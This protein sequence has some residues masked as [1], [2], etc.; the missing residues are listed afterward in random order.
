MRTTA[1][2][3]CPLVL[4][5]AVS[6][7][8]RATETADVKLAGVG[9]NPDEIGPSPERFGGFVEYM[10]VNLAGGALPL[11]TLGL[12]SYDE[13]GPN[14]VG[15]E[16]P[17]AMVNGTAFIMETNAADPDALFGSFTT[18]P[19]VVGAC[20]TVFE[21]NSYLSSL[22]DVGTAIRFANADETVAFDLGRR[23]LVYPPKPQDV[24]S[25]YSELASW[26]QNSRTY[27]AIG[28]ETTSSPATMVDAVLQTA[29]FKHG[30]QVYMSFPGG[31]PPKDAN[32]GAIPVPLA[33]SDATALTLPNR[34]S[35][36]ILAWNGPVFD[37]Y[38]VGQS[39][40]A[41]A[42][43]LQYA[44]GSS[45][46]TGVADCLTL[47]A[48]PTDG[49]GATG[50]V[51]TGPWDTDD[52]Q[53]SFTWVSPGPTAVDGETLGLSVRFL[54]AVERDF[55]YMV[56]GQTQV[57]DADGNVVG[58]RDL[59]ACDSTED[60]EWVFDTALEISEDVSEE[61]A[62][63]YIP[64]LRGDPTHTV[65]EVSCN[66]GES[67]SALVDEGGEPV[68]DANGAPIYVSTFT[69]TN[70]MVEQALSYALE[71]NAQGA[72]FYLSRT[73]SRTVDT[74]PVRDRYGQKRDIAEVKVVSRSIEVGRF[75]FEN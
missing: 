14:M 71:H 56:V 28:P 55:E 67:P 40:G 17:Y 8:G 59:L 57:K 27:K 70:D 36:A 20:Q 16:P 42:A 52:G 60:V 51:Y 25:Y 41:S 65:A 7:C 49:E 15:F 12:L 69:L 66:V 21:P 6:G 18:P 47:A 53:V 64:S 63:E 1:I 74:P 11:G 4:A 32:V 30:E 34:T 10:W 29:N 75:W 5:L 19:A 2:L 39:T 61:H 54:G 13:A 22:A 48:L 43:C 38:G 58:T 45:A 50:Q 72:I 23:P 68:V 37:Q 26:R 44:A 35:A 73:T 33:P 24:F 3:F 62:G 31:L 46:P 9:L